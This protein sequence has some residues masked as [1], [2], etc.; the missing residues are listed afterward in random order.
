[1]KPYTLGLYEKALPAQLSWREKLQQAGKLGF[2]A[3]EI[4]IDETDDRLARLDWPAS[5]RSELVSLMAGVGVPIRTMCLSGHRKYPLGAKLIPP[6]AAGGW[7]S[8]K[9]PSALRM[10]WAFAS[11]SS[12]GTTSTARGVHPRYPRLV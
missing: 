10:I 5:K 1:M 4:S 11:S 12:R 6:S 3:L 8:W 9:R 2:D 7:R